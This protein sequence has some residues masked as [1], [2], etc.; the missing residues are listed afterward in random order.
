[1]TLRQELTQVTQ[2]KISLASQLTQCNGAETFS[3]PQ[4]RTLPH[5]TWVKQGEDQTWKHVLKIT[6]LMTR[7]GIL[8]KT[9][10]FTVGE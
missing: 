9:N 7:R 4:I 6:V 5:N 3:A 1:L 10:I 8:M 2:K